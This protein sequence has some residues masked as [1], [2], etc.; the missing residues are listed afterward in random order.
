MPKKINGFLGENAFANII[1]KLYGFIKKYNGNNKRKLILNARNS[2]SAVL[3]TF[4]RPLTP[5]PKFESRT[6]GHLKTN[7]SV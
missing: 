6:V 7:I 5:T 2:G 4:G 3:F 1:I